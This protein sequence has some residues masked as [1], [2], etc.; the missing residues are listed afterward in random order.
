MLIVWANLRFNFV[1]YVAIGISLFF[2]SGCHFGDNAV[3][4]LVSGLYPNS[5]C[6]IYICVESY[7][8]NASEID[9]NFVVTQNG[10]IVHV[11]GGLGK[12]SSILTEV[13]PSSGDSLSAA[14]GN[15]T[16]QLVDISGGKRIT[17]AGNLSDS[18]PQPTVM[19]NYEHN[20]VV[21]T[22]TVTF[23]PVFSFLTPTPPLTVTR[24]G[25]N[26]ALQFSLPDPSNL[27]GFVAGNCVRVDGSV[28][29]MATTPIPYRY[30]GVVP[31]G[32]AFQGT[33]AD[34]DSSLNAVSGKTGPNG[35]D[36]S[37]VQTCDLHISWIE[38]YIGKTSAGLSEHSN[39]TAKAT[40]TNEILYNGQH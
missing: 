21:Y 1:K 20:G 22:S 24:T 31:G 3:D 6:G 12:G 23:L 27:S 37:P 40:I 7:T 9:V 35:T 8:L 30:A 17:Y 38:T 29:D 39:Y 19:L 11:E 36:S 14:I 33:A 2:L 32:I 5:P 28:A 25:G 4:S 15:Q 13:L 34:L 16:V 26:F 10:N 18:E